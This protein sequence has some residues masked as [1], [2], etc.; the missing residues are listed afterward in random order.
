MN[1]NRVKIHG[2]IGDWYEAEFTVK[3]SFDVR[4]VRVHSPIPSNLE[5]K[6]RAA[7]AAKANCS[8]EDVEIYQVFRMIG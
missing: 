5:S 3:G 2:L 8:Y 6:I 7:A 4:R 1:I